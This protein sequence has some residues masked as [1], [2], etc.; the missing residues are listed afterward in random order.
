MSHKNL[1]SLLCVLVVSLA[2]I[3]MAQAADA[4]SATFAAFYDAKSSIGWIWAGIAAVSVGVLVLIGAPVIGPIMAPTITAIGTS[5]GGLFGLSGIAATNFGLALLGG[6]A[7]SAGGLGIAGGTTLLAVTLTFGTEV[8]IDYSVGSLTTVYDQNKFVSDS[9]TLMTLPLPRM[10]GDTESVKAAIEELQPKAFSDAWSC[11]K[12]R[13]ER[14]EVFKGC[15]AGQQ[16]SARQRVRN[17][18]A[19]M[20]RYKPRG[21]MTKKNSEQRSAMLA[22]LYFIDNDYASAKIEAENAYRLGLDIGHQPTLPAFI[23]ST[24]QLYDE[25]PDF[26]DSF[27]RLQY[28]V[29]AEPNNALT[30]LLFATYLDRLSYRLNEGKAKIKDL[31]RVSVLANSKTLPDDERKLAVNQMLLAHD[32]MQAKVNQQRILSL[33]G[34]TNQTVINNPK[35]VT[36]VKTALNNYGVVLEEAGTMVQRQESLLSGLEKDV[37]WSQRV[38]KA[39]DALLGKVDPYNEQEVSLIKFKYALDKYKSG[40]ADLTARVRAFELQLEEEK[41]SWW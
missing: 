15:M 8:V 36:F 2:C 10:T 23:Q 3:S 6:G 24:S 14:L 31:Q 13:P 26:Q 40:K 34:T 35:T 25:S 20:K 41:K 16:I 5:I 17:A 30:P 22:L 12:T 4:G 1:V 33:T 19:T 11:M 27:N 21:N 28:A 9:R 39:K 37:R 7:L 38:R 18:I 32:L 29:K